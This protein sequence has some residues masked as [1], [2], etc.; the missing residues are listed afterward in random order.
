MPPDDGKARVPQGDGI[1][2]ACQRG[3][4]VALAG[5]RRRGSQILHNRQSTGIAATDRLS[6]ALKWSEQ[7]AG[8][9]CSPP[10]RATFSSSAIVPN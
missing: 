10:L 3:H 2:D 9:I 1:L 6:G 7:Q 4:A 8:R 5:G